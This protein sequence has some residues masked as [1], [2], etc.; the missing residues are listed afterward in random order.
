MLSHLYNSLLASH[1]TAA[2][3]TSPAV[4]GSGAT[5]PCSDACLAMAV[6]R[7]WPL[8]SQTNPHPIPNLP[9]SASPGRQCLLK[10]HRLIGTC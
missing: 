8:Q 10:G 5:M 3:A 2:P 6:R 9:V 4:G 7:C 1:P